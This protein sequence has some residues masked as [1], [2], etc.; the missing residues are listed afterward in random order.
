MGCNYI[1]SCSLH[2]GASIR[3]IYTRYLIEI[4]IKRSAAAGCG[5]L[6]V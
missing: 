1:L 4:E 5:Y 6:E 2:E 3:R